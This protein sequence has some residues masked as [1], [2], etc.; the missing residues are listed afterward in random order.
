[1][2]GSDHSPPGSAAD[3]A[4]YAAAFAARYGSGG[5]FW[6]AHPDLTAKPVDTFEIW[7]E[8]DSR[9]FWAP[10]PDPAR[11]ADLYTQ[12]RNAI[13]AAD[14]DARVIIGGLAY[15]EVF[16]PALL[17]A[18]PGLRGHVDGVGIHPYAS[19]PLGVL[20]TVGHARATMEA[21]GL[22]SVPLYVT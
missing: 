13:L 20:A 9:N 15:P 19:N 2:P 18:A 17:S 14:A 12:A 4:A 1:V 5:S 3:F 10:V 21:L 8:P 6:S 11:Y 22:G 7:N 16:L